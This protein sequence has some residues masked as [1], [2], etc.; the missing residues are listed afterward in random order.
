MKN[1]YSSDDYEN[2]KIINDNLIINTG[3]TKVNGQIST[4]ETKIIIRDSVRKANKGDIRHLIKISVKIMENDKIKI[5][6]TIKVETIILNNNNH[7]HNFEINQVNDDILLSY[8][9]S[10]GKPIKAHAYDCKADD[11]IEYINNYL[12]SFNG[13]KGD[14]DFELGLE[15]I[16]PE[17]KQVIEYL[18]ELWSN[19]DLELYVKKQ[20]ELIK[21]CE[22]EYL[23]KVNQIK[24]LIQ[25]LKQKDDENFKIIVKTI[26]PELEEIIEP[27][28]ELG[29]KFNVEEYIKRQQEQIKLCEI[30]YLEKVNPIRNHIKTLSLISNDIDR[31]KKKTL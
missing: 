15:K 20:K 2:T 24:D 26:Y 6:S 16:Y 10:L 21:E 19:F 17:L 1:N 13:L 8:N 11:I 29:N 25:V 28:L 18:L 7:S 9:N 4:Y 22:Y 23:A 30:N 12:Y 31:K 3:L 5:P 14:N 27:I